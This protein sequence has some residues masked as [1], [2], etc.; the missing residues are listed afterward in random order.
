M[1]VLSQKAGQTLTIG[2]T[3]LLH[4]LSIDG[5]QVKVG[6]EAPITV[7]VRRGE[8]RPARGQ[9]SAERSKTR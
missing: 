6:I 9:A 3:I 4:I 1:L 2:D 8:L 5:N 7:R